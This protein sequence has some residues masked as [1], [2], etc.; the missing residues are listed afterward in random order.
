MRLWTIEPVASAE[1]PRWQER[2][3]WRRVVVRAE[4]AAAARVMAAELER[5][6]G[7]PSDGNGSASFR[8]GFEDEKLYWVKPTGEAP[9]VPEDDG[10]SPGIVVAEPADSPA[11]V[12]PAP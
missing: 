7:E 1:D 4:S 3:I 8:S 6:E 12:A 10:E 5:S 9:A 11:A 2:T